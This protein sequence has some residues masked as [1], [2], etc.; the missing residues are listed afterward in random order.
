MT[1]EP[2]IILLLAAAY[3]IRGGWEALPLPDWLGQIIPRLLV[4]GNAL[5]ISYLLHVNHN[6]NMF[7]AAALAASGYLMMMIPH[8]YVMNA[9]WFQPPQVAK[10][11]LKD[12]WPTA[13][14]PWQKTQEQW[15]G[16]PVWERC[17]HCTWQTSF[18]MLLRSLVAFVPYVLLGGELNGAIKA[19]AIITALCPLSNV[20]GFVIVPH[21]KPWSGALKTEEV[22]HGAVWG[23]AFTQL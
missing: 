3:S 6:A 1:Y 19:C 23:L 8:T 22:F 10:P 17:W 15:T 4:W 2:I 16:M 18:I 13:W 20:I 11:L 7:I 21:G 12:H 9:I 5:C 14:W